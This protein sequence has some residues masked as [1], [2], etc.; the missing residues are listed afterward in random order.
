[1]FNNKNIKAALK[2]QQN[3]IMLSNK[4]FHAKNK[5]IYNFIMVYDNEL[6]FVW[7]KTL[8]PVWLWF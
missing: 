2:L 3:R 4:H 6:V 5:D 7:L 1:M 8:N